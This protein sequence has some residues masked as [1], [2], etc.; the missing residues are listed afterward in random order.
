MLIKDLNLVAVKNNTSIKRMRN[1]I[2]RTLEKASDDH[3]ENGLAWYKSA[4]DECVDLAINSP[5]T[6]HQVAAAVA[7]L[8]PRQRWSKNITYAKMVIET[9]NAPCLNRSIEKA[10]LALNSDNPIETFSPTALKTKSFYHNLLNEY[11]PVTIDMWAARAALGTEDAEKILARSG[12]YNAISHSYKLAAK[13]FG[14]TPAQTQA[15]TW[16]AIRNSHV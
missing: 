3:I 14:S 6:I 13:D 5:Y 12:M 8:S 16:C 11:D 4:Y 7:H 10:K 15:V 9:G 1:A 2:N